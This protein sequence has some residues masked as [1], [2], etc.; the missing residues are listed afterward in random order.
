MG[1]YNS[2]INFIT[3]IQYIYINKLAE[4]NIALI[5]S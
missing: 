3:L 5:Y 2:V 4:G 1:K